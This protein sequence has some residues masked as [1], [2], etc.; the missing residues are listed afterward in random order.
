MNLRTDIAH[1]RHEIVWK[2]HTDGVE[3]NQW[4]EGETQITLTEIKTDEAERIMDKQRGKYVTLKMPEFSH[5]SELIDG[6]LDVLTK[7][8]KC[9][10]PE[11]AKTFLVAGLGNENITPDALGPLC[12]SKILST[13]HFENYLQDDM[14]LSK[15]NP[16]SAISTG[17]LG[18]TG[19]ET[20]EYING[21]AKIV[22]PDLV[23][24][25][26]ALA[27]IKESNLCKTIQITDTGITPGSGV[28]NYRKTIDKETLGIPI[29]SIGVPTVISL[30]NNEDMIVTPREIDTIIKRASSLIAMGINCAIQPAADAELFLALS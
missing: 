25:I 29:I 6:R 10:F 28:G 17:V 23:I 21:V 24:I 2:K 22:K 13:R 3:V 15:L 12:A 9:L 1:E 4:T 18:Q 30:D 26:D 27:T 20:A 8:I 11:R 16:V 19:I 5:E 14:F 7:Q